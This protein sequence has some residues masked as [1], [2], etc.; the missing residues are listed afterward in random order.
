[1]NLRQTFAAD[2]K[3]GESAYLEGI[4]CEFLAQS[5]FE[6]VHE[7]SIPFTRTFRLKYPVLPPVL[8]PVLLSVNLSVK[9][10]KE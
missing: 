6:N 8:L 2:R 9:V 5:A 1:M 4:F 3:S 7:G 10:V